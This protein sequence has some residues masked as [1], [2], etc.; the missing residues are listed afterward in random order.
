MNVI[1]ETNCMRIN[2]DNIV[3]AVRQIASFKPQLRVFE[4]YYN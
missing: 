1:F 3:Y 2:K 4:I